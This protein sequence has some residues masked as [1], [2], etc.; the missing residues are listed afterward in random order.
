MIEVMI[1]MRT[2]MMSVRH[3]NRRKVGVYIASNV[4]LTT[5]HCFC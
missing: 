2:I 4:L 5:H 1:I 3:T